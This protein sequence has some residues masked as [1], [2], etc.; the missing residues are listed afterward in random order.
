M[1]TEEVGVSRIDRRGQGASARA[2]RLSALG[3]GVLVLLALAVAAPSAAQT[4][5]ADYPLDTDLA[6]ATGHYAN[7]ILLGNPTPPSPPTGASPLCQNGIYI[8]SPGGQDIQT[9]PL[10]GLDPTDFE[11]EVEFILTNLGQ[12]R[13]VIVAGT[14]YRWIGIEVST[15]GML[16]ILYN[17]SNVSWSSTAVTSGGWYAA[18]VVFANETASLYLNDS[19]I[20]TV[21][22]GPLATG[23]HYEFT[24]TNR[25]S[26]F[27]LYGCIRNLRFYNGQAPVIP[28]LGVAGIAGLVLLLAGFSV[29][30]LRRRL[31]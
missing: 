2:P 16:G 1:R 11:L 7:V 25:A 13:P 5:V 28:A 4:L 14:M 6:D 17:N 9:P 24:T 8:D 30:I 10:T 15:T 23:N 21:E 19:L 12:Q 26:G 31:A 29:V 22:T 27:A 20:H 3:A 18:R